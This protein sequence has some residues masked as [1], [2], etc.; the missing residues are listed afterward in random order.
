VCYECHGQEEAKG[1]LASRKC[2]VCHLG[3]TGLTPASHAP[4]AAPTP[5][6]GGAKFEITMPITLSNCSLCHPNLDGFDNPALNSKFKHDVHFA[7]RIRCLACHQEYPHQQSELIKPGMGVCVVCHGLNHGNQGLMAPKEC[8]TCHPP[9]FN[10]IPSDHQPLSE[11]RAGVHGKVA[12][13]DRRY[14]YSC[15]LVTEPGLMPKFCR[16]CH[17][18]PEMPH[19]DRW[20]EELHPVQ[21]KANRQVCYRCHPPGQIF[22]NQCH[23]KDYDPSWG[24]WV[25]SIPGQ[26]QHWRVVRQKGAAFCLTCHGPVFCPGCHIRGSAVRI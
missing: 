7:R 1:V 22:C 19:P 18:V 15:H 16:D 25:S 26:T 21:A 5:S 14:C 20:K 6:K 24:P 2:D 4:G 3:V 8:Q 12:K 10:L 9:D 13:K 23:H 17:G 11:W